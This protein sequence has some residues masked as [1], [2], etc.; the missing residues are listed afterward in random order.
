MQKQFKKYSA[1]QYAYFESY[2]RQ[3]GG[4]SITFTNEYL[5]FEYLGFSE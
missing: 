3:Y 5:T 4:I 2:N 1:K